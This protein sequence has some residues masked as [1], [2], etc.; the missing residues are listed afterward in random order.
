MV[1]EIYSN[2]QLVQT[3]MRLNLLLKF[4]NSI[5]ERNKME[6]KTKKQKQFVNYRLRKFLDQWDVPD[7]DLSNDNILE[8][9]DPDYQFGQVQEIIQEEFLR[10]F[11]DWYGEE[12]GEYELWKD[13]INDFFTNEM[14]EHQFPIGY[15]DITHYND[16]QTIIDDYLES[17]EI[18]EEE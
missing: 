15:G 2:H 18:H 13:Y 9:S 4:N 16:Y 17:W 5:Y 14:K 11:W 8:D 3:S 1:I 7:M 6:T 10:C 12:I